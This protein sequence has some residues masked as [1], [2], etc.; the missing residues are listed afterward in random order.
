[1]STPDAPLA[2]QAAAVATTSALLGNTVWGY[3]VPNDFVR[4]RELSVTATAPDALV[5]RSLR[6]QRASLTLS[7]RNLGLLYN[8][9]PGIDPEINSAVANVGG[10]NNDFFAAPPLRYWLVRVNLGL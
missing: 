5:R 1:V 10:G 4:F 7:G 2:D 8:R 9:Y 3:F 6:L